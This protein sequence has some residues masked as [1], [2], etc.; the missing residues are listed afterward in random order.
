MTIHTSYVICAVQRSGS[1]LLCEALK[2]TGLAGMPEEYFLTHEGEN[3]EEGWW[4]KQHG[5]TSRPAF[6]DLVLEKGTTANGVFGAKLMWNYLHDAIDHFQELPTYQ[7]LEAAEVLSKFMPNLHYIWMVRGDKVRQA[8]SWMIA[9]QTGIYAAWQAEGKSVPEPV[10]DFEQIDLLYNLVLEGEAGWQ[11]YFESIG[12]VPLK[13][14]YEELVDS[15]EATALQVLDYL[16]VA[17][18]PDLA[19]GERRMKKQGT[20]LNERWA[21]K[22]REMKWG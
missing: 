18:S 15:Y 9:A 2:N 12:V 20:G 22:Y 4:A 13:I 8:V 7:E 11:A 6:L 16:S 10:F 19:F 17:Y 5:A 21:E 14:I 3:W 1:F